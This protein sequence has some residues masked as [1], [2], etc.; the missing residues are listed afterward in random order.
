M[1]GER[2]EVVS[3]WSLVMGE[4]HSGFCMGKV[5][6][7]RGFSGKIENREKKNQSFLEGRFL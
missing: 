4:V 5:E 2:K 7:E 1:C 6:N 3:D